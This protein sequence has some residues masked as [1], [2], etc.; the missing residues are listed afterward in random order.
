[1]SRFLDEASAL[2]DRLAESATWDGACATWLARA[3]PPGEDPE[4]PEAHPELV[5]L[6]AT[7]YRGTAGVALV[8]AR[9]AARTGERAHRRAARGAMEHALRHA[10]GPGSEGEPVGAEWRLS[11]L[12]G[13]LGVAWAGHE[14]GLLLDDAALSRRG[15][16]L[17]AALV[18][19]GAPGPEVDV[20]FGAGSGIPTLL[21]L[22][23]RGVRGAPELAARLG[24]AALAAGRSERGGLAWRDGLTGYSHGAAGVGSALAALAARTDAER[25]RAGARA[26]FAYERALFQPR[27]ANWPDLKAKP[28]ADGSWPCEANWCHGAPG[29]GL[30]RALALPRL[31]DPA[32][33]D[34][35]RV[36]LATTVARLRDDAQEPG[37]DFTLCHGVAGRAACALRIGHAVGGDAGRSAAR[38][39]V[40]AAVEAFGARARQRWGEATD[41]PNPLPAGL[42]PS[43]F[44]GAAGIAHL[45]LELD[46]PRLPGV[47]APPGA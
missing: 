45:F 1:V 11:F 44:L 7:V 16:R 29:I 34:E 15:L 42:H 25:H 8:L 38:E 6:D 43:L 39:V 26:A 12:M 24:D 17:A 27:D 28:R 33:L 21:D 10:R 41:W 2:A 20:M 13:S 35:A 46:D 9:V 36:A 40:G 5:G 37:R 47:V 23:A 4:G 31:K 19:D 18:R 22:G 32:L 14:V 30:S 3:I